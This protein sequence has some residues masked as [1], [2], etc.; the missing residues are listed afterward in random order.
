MVFTQLNWQRVYMQNPDEFIKYFARI[1]GQ[2][3]GLVKCMMVL[4]WRVEQLTDQPT[5]VQKATSSSH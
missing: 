3:D 2:I 4:P 5:L 1:F